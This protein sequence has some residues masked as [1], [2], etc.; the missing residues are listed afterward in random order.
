VL[1]S[2]LRSA[3]SVLDN[4]FAEPI[5][6]KL[7]FAEQLLRSLFPER[8]FFDCR[9]EPVCVLRHS[10]FCRGHSAG[11]IFAGA[12]LPGILLLDVAAGTWLP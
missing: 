11:V 1:R 12:W 4:P 6:E 7:L 3:V 9:Y 5:A 10:S 8:C 2:R